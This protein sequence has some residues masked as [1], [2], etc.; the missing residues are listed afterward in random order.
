MLPVCHTFEF[1]VLFR[2]GIVDGGET[3]EGQVP[4]R[5][6]GRFGRFWRRRRS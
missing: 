3:R 5:W 4:W 2:R 6:T 1:Y